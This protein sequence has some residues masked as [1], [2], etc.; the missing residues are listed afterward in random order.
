MLRAHTLFFLICGLALSAWAAHAFKEEW[1]ASRERCETATVLIREAQE[2]LRLSVEAEA[3]PFVAFHALPSLVEP[4]IAKYRDS[5]APLLVE[6]WNFHLVRDDF[7]PFSRLLL[8]SDT[9][10]ALEALRA[11]AEHP[12]KCPIA[13][14]SRGL[15]SVTSLRDWLATNGALVEQT[16]IQW[17]TDRNTVCQTERTHQAL[18]LAQR[19]LEERCAKAKKR[20]CQPKQVMEFRAELEEVASRLKLNREKIQKKWGEKLAGRVLCSHP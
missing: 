10:S 11:I 16:K 12:E 20:K 3:D 8:S 13:T 17:W 6:A 15:A 19:T 5:A 9:K 14:R 18:S 1:D 7:T 4:A 2:V